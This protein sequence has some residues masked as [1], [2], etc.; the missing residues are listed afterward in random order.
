MREPAPAPILSVAQLALAAALAALAIPRALGVI[1]LQAGAPFDLT[2]EV[3]TVNTILLLRQGVDVYAP[4]TF[5]A[6]PFN[7]LMYP[8]AY[9]YLVAALPWPSGVN[10][11]GPP[12]LASAAA[13]LVAVGALFWVPARRAGFVL[14]A[15]AA[16]FFL[17]IPA[18][19]RNIAYARQDP[20]ALALSLGAVLVLS[21][22]TSR[23]AIVASASLAAL[24]V[25]TKQ[26]YVSAVIAC[27]LYLWRLRWTSGL[28]FVVTG[29][30]IGGIAAAGAHLAWGAGFW[31]SVLVAPT[32]SFDWSQY[33]AFPAE[34]ASQWAY[35]T[36]LVAGLAIWAWTLARPAGRP[37][38]P[39]SPLTL[40]VP[41]TFVVLALTLGKRGAGLNYFFEPTLALLAYLVERGDRP[42]R[43]ARTSMGL[44]LALLAFLGLFVVDHVRIPAER[45][46]FATPQK[47]AETD[48]FIHQ[49]K[50]EVAALDG[51]MRRILF[52]PYMLP[53][54]SYN[55]GTPVYVND[56]YLYALLWTE[57][58]LPVD[59]FIASV[60]DAYFDLIVLPPDEDPSRPKYGF[61]TGTAAFYAALRREYRLERTGVFQY[62]VRRVNPNAGLS[63]A[64][65]VRGG[66]AAVAARVSV[67][68]PLAGGAPGI[69]ES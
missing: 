55:L 4:G 29:G 50:A 1:W 65:P 66:R 38:Q 33:R 25:L 67:G 32:Q 12:R 19:T 69:R 34:M 52:P 56:P 16:A 41:A 2:L 45:Y 31:W 24:A 64:P 60:R 28:T 7:V 23:G 46:T 22:R 43:S 62:H 47:L 5:D 48:R 30:L 8:P 40:Y 49:F 59:A 51:P 15:A 20:M 39:V 14:A 37:P 42:P 11:F 18:V 53:N 36:F 21:R 13:M 58:K 10:P 54:Y 26:S 3:P 6:L 61:R 63:D 57:G 9:H 44:A 17:A 35:A 68:C 27:A